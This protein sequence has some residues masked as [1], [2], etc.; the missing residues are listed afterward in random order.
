MTQNGG[1][2][3]TI[4]VNVVSGASA[5]FQY[6]VQ[7]FNGCPSN[8]STEVTIFGPDPLMLSLNA[9]ESTLQINCFGESNGVISVEAMGG[10][11]NNMFELY[12]VD[13]A[14]AGA[15][16]IQGPF[17]QGVFSSL[18]AGTSYYVSAI[19]VDCPAVIGP[20][21][22]E[23]PAT[24]IT[25][26]APIVNNI[27]CNGDGDGS[28]EM[29]V[30]GG[31]PPY[32]YIISS[33]PL[34][35]VDN[36]ILEATLTIDN[37]EVCIDSDD[38]RISLNITGG[39]TNLTTGYSY[40]INDENGTYVPVTT[41]PLLIDVDG[42]ASYTIY[43]QDDEPIDLTASTVISDYNCDQTYDIT[44]DVDPQ[45]ANDVMYSIDDGTTFQMSNIFTNVPSGSTYA[46]QVLHA[47]GCAYGDDETFEV[48]LEVFADLDI[49]V[50][51]SGI[52]EFVAQGVD[53]TAPFEYSIDGITFDSNN[54][55]NVTATGEYTV[56]VRDAIGCEAQ[57]T[58]E[59]E[60][61]GVIVPN[62][63]TPNGDGR[64]D[65]W[66]PTGLEF[67]PNA[68][69][70]VFDRYGRLLR[71]FRGDFNPGW[72]GLYESIELPSGDYW[73]VIQLNDGQSPDIK[74]HFTLYR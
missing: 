43:V 38:G 19:S 18:P 16:P 67:F 30:S 53:G 72:T 14:S 23:E 49:A 17:A 56:T 2:R 39:T 33:D 34:R 11:G 1:S 68:Q 58:I 21:T 10:L 62:F 37:Q 41:N 24:A 50:E 9:E 6:Y 3:E 63:F 66:M 61:I 48:T 25:A 71:T 57:T 55:F 8:A 65:Y 42:G 31:T 52:D 51:Q 69:I 45:Y 46:L 36:P 35:T 70:K 20:I 26:S 60:Y 40:S 4:N 29:V 22:I 7:D 28:A 12:D 32:T 5:S 74:G 54:V 47:S 73:Y 27:Q 64:N 59:F 15:T 44:I 13:P